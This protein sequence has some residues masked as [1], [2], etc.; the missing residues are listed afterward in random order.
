MDTPSCL[1]HTHIFAYTVGSDR[2]KG[3][4]IA[5]YATIKALEALTAP[6]LSFKALT[7]TNYPLAEVLGYGTRSLTPLVEMIEVDTP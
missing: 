5:K 3:E 7:Q 2:K 6:P 4:K 1:G